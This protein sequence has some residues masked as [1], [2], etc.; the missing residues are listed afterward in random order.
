MATSQGSA[1]CWQHSVT[2]KQNIE[3]SDLNIGCR[4]LQINGSAMYQI[5]KL[6]I[7]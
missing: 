1:G 2:A 7:H 6:F 3:L 5:N 4:K